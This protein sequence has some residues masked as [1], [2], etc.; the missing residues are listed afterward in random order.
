MAGVINNDTNRSVAVSNVTTGANIAF[1]GNITDTGT[2]IVVQQN[3]GGTVTFVGDLDMD[4]DTAGETA[5]LVADNT[6]ATID[7][8]GDVNI[9]STSTA[10]GFVATGGGTLSMPSTVNS[11]STE[12][13]RAS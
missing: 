10:E 5:V 11:I 8:A 12:T 2:G 6:G 3:S 9:N 4:I 7:F 1:N 13:G